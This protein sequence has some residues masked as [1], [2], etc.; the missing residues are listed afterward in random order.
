MSPRFT[1]FFTHPL[2]LLP[3]AFLVHVGAAVA[4]DSAGDVQQQ[5]RDL[6]SGRGQ[7]QFG[8]PAERSGDR[9]AKSPDDAHDSARRLLL[10]L[11]ESPRPGSRAMAQPENAAHQVS[12]AVQRNAHGYDDAQAMARSLI[13]GRSDAAAGGGMTRG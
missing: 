2:A 3:A 12:S 8:A 11:T 4:G 6:L 5:V 1:R 9:T 7:A 10:G 13:L